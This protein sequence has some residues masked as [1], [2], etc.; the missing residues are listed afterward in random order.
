MAFRAVCMVQG[1]EHFGGYE[2]PR[3]VDPAGSVGEAQQAA[4][5]SEAISVSVGGRRPATVFRSG[6]YAIPV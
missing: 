4:R 1:P 5:P 6:P 3:G 2:T